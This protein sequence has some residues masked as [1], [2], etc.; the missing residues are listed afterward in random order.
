MPWESQIDFRNALFTK[1]RH[2]MSYYVAYCAK[3]DKVGLQDWKKYMRSF[4]KWPKMAKF[5]KKI[6]NGQIIFFYG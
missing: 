1:I 5:V 2:I 6:K 4:K 3:T